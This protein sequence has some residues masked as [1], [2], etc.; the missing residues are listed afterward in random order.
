MGAEL[1]WILLGLSLPVLAGIW[2]WTAR[3]AGQAPGNAE[4]RESTPPLDPR[5]ADADERFAD[6]DDDMRPQAE[7]R[8]WGVPPFEPLN[9]RTA[10]FDRV[11]VLD[12][13][14]MVNADPAPAPPRAPGSTL[15]TATAS[16]PVPVTSSAQPPPAVRSASDT[17]PVVEPGDRAA[18]APP[19]ADA[20]ELQRIVT[21][22][23]CA[24]GETRWSGTQLMS[25]LEVHGL[26]FGRYQVFHR[27]HVD[28]RTL[29][30][31]ASLIE[32]GTFDVGEMADQEF[33]GVTLF[34]VLP[35]PLRPLDT[36][37]EI[38]GT[39]RGLAEELSAMVQ[40]AKGVPLSPQRAAALREDIA[41]F[42]ASLPGN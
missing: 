23:V 31:V 18:A 35:G 26:A 21:I 3:R 6:A 28:G 38:L 25:A 19:V 12:G 40:D 32:P 34:A 8:D 33:R 15:A 17:E 20:A 5:F 14:M 2:W 4:L 37:D 42:Q 39:A 11:P 9:I 24:V 36:L 29:F 16:R 30:C 1:R 7:S 41:H 13:P 27:K 22:R 10:D